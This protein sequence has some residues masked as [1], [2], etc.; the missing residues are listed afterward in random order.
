MLGEWWLAEALPPDDDYP[1]RERTVAGTFDGGGDGPWV[2]STNG[3]L[4]DDFREPVET[5]RGVQ[6]P[7]RTIWGMTRDRARVS[8][9][10][11]FLVRHP[12]MPRHARDGGQRWHTDCYV[13]GRSRVVASDDVDMIEVEF[14]D[15]AA[16]AGDI[17]DFDYKPDGNGEQMEPSSFVGIRAA[18]FGGVH[19]S[20]SP[21][22][23]KLA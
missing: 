4:G 21:R 17:S 16:W 14:D 2:L 18:G 12:P 5:Q 10:D 9:L 23:S 3:L 20:R 1:L 6:P 15:L 22:A 11:C 8:L 7:R 19:V 13:T